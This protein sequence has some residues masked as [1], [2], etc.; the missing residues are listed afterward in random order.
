MIDFLI[1]LIV[2]GLATIGLMVIEG[3]CKN[4]KFV[5][6]LNKLSGYSDDEEES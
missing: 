5:K 3:P 2:F 6:L 4:S 1:I